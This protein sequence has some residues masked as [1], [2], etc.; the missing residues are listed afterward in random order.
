VLAVEQF[1]IALDCVGSVGGFGSARIGRVG[2][3]DIAVFAF[4]PER[5]WRCGCEGPQHLCFCQK[6][7]V[8]QRHLGEVAPQ[9]AKIA[10][11]HD[12]L[13]ADGAAHRFHGAAGRR[14][15]IEQKA[16]SGIAQRIDR[17]IHLQRRLRQ[18]PGSER[19]N[20]QGLFCILR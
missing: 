9:T 14:D 13:A 16:F 19:Q 11:T 1:E 3:G 5:P 7:V 2:E 12:G 4:S 15:K 10:D 6:T 8:T 20:P 18:Q 17:V